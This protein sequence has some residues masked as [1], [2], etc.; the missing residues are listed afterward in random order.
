MGD[1]FSR[2]WNDIAASSAERVVGRLS[3]WRFMTKS[4]ADDRRGLWWRHAGT[5]APRVRAALFVVAL[6]VL[7]LMTV[8]AGARAADTL[9]V[10]F[11]TGPAIGTPVNDDYLASA[12]VRFLAADDG[13]RPFRRSAPGLAHSGTVAADVG[14]DVCYADTGDSF[15]CELVTGGTTGRLT[16]TASAVSLYAGLFTSNGGFPFSVHL[17]GYRAD[18]SVAATGALTSR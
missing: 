11:E 15:G 2:P 6:A 1:P 3:V 16:R 17:V 4:P 18:G 12:F 5:R 14:P 7:A 13:F 9:T 8:P 10:D